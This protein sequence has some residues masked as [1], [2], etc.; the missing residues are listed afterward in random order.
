MALNVEAT[1]DA[2]PGGHFEGDLRSALVADLQRQTLT[3]PSLTL[4]TMELA[5]NGQLDVKQLLGAPQMNGSLQ[6]APFSP[7]E[8][9]RRLDMSE[10]I[11]VDPNVMQQAALEFQFEGTT[12]T[13][14]SDRK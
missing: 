13:A 14:T 11:P 9:L 2:L 5:L 1:G 10:S 6:V 8:L 4:K 7:R 12:T 3:V